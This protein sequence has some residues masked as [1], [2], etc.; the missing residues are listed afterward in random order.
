MAADEG[1]DGIGRVDGSRER[2]RRLLATIA[3][4]ALALLPVAA[5]PADVSDGVS[6]EVSGDVDGAPFVREV[7]PGHFVHVGRHEDLSA[8]N[9]G[10]VANGG[11]VIGET[12]VAVIDPGGSSA[13][14]RRLAAALRERTALPVTHVVL[15]HFHP[16]HVF[17]AHVFAAADGAPAPLVVAHARHARA[18]VQRG[19]HYLER[20]PTLLDAAPD[21]A[22]DRRSGGAATLVAPTRTVAAG[23]TLEIDLG[24]RVLAVHGWPTA[25]TDN[26]VSVLDAGAGVLWTGDLLVEG[27]TPSLDG[28]LVDWLDVLDALE[29]LGAPLV[30]PGHGEPGASAVTLAPVRRYLGALLAD[31]RERVA[32][33]GRLAEA[34]AVAERAPASGWVL[35]ALHHPRN[36]ARAWSEL[37][38]E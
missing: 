38:W 21:A 1:R 25:H 9:R 29:R 7:A 36:V 5:T 17:G 27:R 6:G 28:N 31:T 15:T 11:F 14:A 32:A 16:D 33:G 8:A 34:L 10:D 12:G 23:E 3:A 18:A 35:F 26:D 22:T 13:V 20:F 4:S 24:N 19:A 30:V 37:E 2:A